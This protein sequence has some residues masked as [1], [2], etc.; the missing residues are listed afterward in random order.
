MNQELSKLIFGTPEYVFEHGKK[1]LR[2]KRK[3]SAVLLGPYQIRNPVQAFGFAKKILNPFKKRKKS[4]FNTRGQTAL[5]EALG[6][7]P[8]HEE[9]W[10]GAKKVP[11]TCYQWY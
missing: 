4:L 2:K 1:Q 9:P 8:P 6:I 5:E 3:L 7:P 10:Q 11:H